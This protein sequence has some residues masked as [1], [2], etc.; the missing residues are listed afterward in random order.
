MDIR[1]SY[2]ESKEANE[3]FV[4][5]IAKLIYPSN[6]HYNDFDVYATITY[7]DN[8][9]KN[10]KV[11]VSNKYNILIDGTPTSDY[12][13]EGGKNLLNS[14]YVLKVTS[15]MKSIDFNV[16]NKGA[17][18]GNSYGGTFAGTD[19]GIHYDVERLVNDFYNGAG[20]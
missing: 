14:S 1:N 4:N 8:T 6:K 7:N 19:K 5:V 15:N 10:I 13:F 9:T 16:L 20:Q 18:D 3:D 17:L 11:D 2:M 12:E